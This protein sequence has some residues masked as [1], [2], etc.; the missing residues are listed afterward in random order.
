[1]NSHVMEKVLVNWQDRYSVG[2]AEIDE[3]HKALFSTINRLWSVIV[4]KGEASV[5]LGL[6][7]E[8]ERYTVQH[9]S[10]EEIFMR[11]VNYPDFE[12]H[13]KLHAQFVQ[14]VAQEKGNVVA[15]KSLSLDLLHFLKDWL[16]EH[17]LVEDQRY[18]TFYGESRKKEQGLGALF[19]RFWQ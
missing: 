19:K 17:I 7:D 13:K 18:A 14:R 6:L 8:L 10:A 11:Q 12:Q 9:F 3:Q 5:V 4:G 2:M 16:I 15:G 1:M